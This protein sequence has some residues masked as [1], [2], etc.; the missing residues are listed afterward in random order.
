MNRTGVVLAWGAVSIVGAAA[1]AYVALHR[2][3]P[4]NALWLV[5]AAT[6]CFA[7]G[8][9]FYSKFIAAKI[10]ALD[11][12]RATPAE[13]LD[14]GRDF[15]VTN[16]WVV[17]GHHF[18]A[19]AGP[20]PLVGPVLAVQFGYLPGTLWV[21]AGAVFAGCVQDFVILLFSVRRDGKSLTEMAKQE[22][23]RIG[24]LVAYGAVIA[25]LVILLAVVALIVVN[26]LR[27]SPWATFTIAMTIPIAL[28]MGVY[29]R[30]IRPGKVLEV[31]VIGF[32]LVL[33][34][35][36]G[37][38][39][40]SQNPAA[41]HLFTLSAATLA[42]LIMIYGF[43]A[44]ALPVWLLLAPRD[45]LSTFVKLGTIGLLGIGMVALHPTLH[46]PALTRFIDGTGPV[47]SG[48]VF[49]FAFITIACGAISGFHSLISSG[50]TPKLIARETET[51]IVGYGAMMC[52]SAV[53]IMAIIAA[54][55]MQPGV[56]FAINSPAGIVGQT[57]AA[58]TTT[59][60]NWGFPV[61]A[62][63][64]QALA[65][66]VGEQTLFNRTG[67]APAFAVGMAHIFSQSLGGERLMAIWYHFAVMFEA[68]FI[69]TILDAGTRVARFMIQDACGHIYKP[70]GRTSWY[71]SILVTSALIV[72]AWGY[73][74]WQG[75][76]DPLGG[77]NSLWPLFG[78]A[79][80]L[81]ATVA[82]CVATTII[83]KLHRARYAAVTLVPLAWL[84]AVTFTAAWHKVFDPSPRIGFLAQARAL[85]AG[86]V[87]A[88][89]ARVIFNNRLDAVV[90]AILVVMVTLVLIESMRQW[91]GILMGREEVTVKEAPFVMTRL[92]EER[93]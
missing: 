28:L 12:L 57:A 8:Y 69:L 7:L 44:S 87:T 11:A 5:V 73:F 59:I 51:R 37:G 20:G 1:V 64:M 41:A 30:R 82:L 86:P 58:A 68:L 36:W 43:A 4:I 70:L 76:K 17:F 71:P 40:A 52:E 88:A 84:V 18:A 89:T 25:I 39:W 23:G 2:G 14:N 24:G 91:I 35:I 66:A 92:A 19:I 90:T 49:P 6:C 85:A 16:K 50:T 32:I 83:I 9:C 72:A 46:M 74:L 47:F 42:I 79:N 54:C 33:L 55:V 13:R 45:Y 80:Q 53:A 34:A 61:T 56:Y 65:H 21:L 78:I 27:D 10:L 15:V 77:I 31:S 81:L 3:E 22:I 67:G 60:S 29:L 48:K 38:Q 75:V 63:Q 93:L 26:A 62:P